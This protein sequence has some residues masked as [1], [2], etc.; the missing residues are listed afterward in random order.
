MELEIKPDPQPGQGHYY[1]SDHFSLARVGIPAFSISAGTD[2]V[3]KPADFGKTTFENYNAKH[4][5]QP[6]DEYH[7]DWDFGSMEQM[8][9]FGL[10]LGLDFANTPKLPTWKIGDEFL[11]ARQ[12]SGVQD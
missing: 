10:T 6:S 7:D 5:H 1:R 9:D 8:A 4:Y 12:K 11:A 2:Y 3:G